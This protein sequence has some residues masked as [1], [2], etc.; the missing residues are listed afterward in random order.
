MFEQT[1]AIEMERSHRGWTM[2]ASLAGQTMLIGVAVLVPL[3]FPD[4]LPSA[5]LRGVLVEPPSP[6]PPPAPRSVQIV[7]VI[8]ERA[9]RT[10]MIMG[11]LIAPVT[12]PDKAATII[13]EAPPE[14]GTYSGPGV[15]GGTGVPYGTGSSV[16]T[17]LLADITARAM[18]ALP[19]PV[20]AAKE[21]APPPPPQRLRVGGVVQQGKILHQVMPVYPPLARAARVQGMVRLEGILGKDG[22]V[23]ELRV[24]SG[25]PLLIQAALDAVRQWIYRPTHLNGDPV[26][27]IAP[28]D[29]T[30]TLN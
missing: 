7:D 11:Q 4:S 26:E 16:L 6:P 30:F 5:R 15:P 24:I 22:R 1:F 23:R 9:T 8:I 20:Q 18:T 19:A 10:Q 27:V 29:V 13:D 2:L 21:E 14:T 3:V 25:H 12:M 28:I 17:G